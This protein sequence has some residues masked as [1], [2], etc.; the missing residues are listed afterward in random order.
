[1]RAKGDGDMKAASP[2]VSAVV[3]FQPD[4][5]T[6]LLQHRDNKPGISHPNL[7]VFPGGHGEPGETAEECARREFKEESCYDL[8]ELNLVVSFVDDHVK[9]VPP[10]QLTI[11]WSR[12][13]GRQTIRCMEGQALEFV[14]REN[15]VNVPGYLLDIWDVAIEKLRTHKD[16]CR[17]ESVE[18]NK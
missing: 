8:D 1:M 18:W 10:Y 6:A 3:L 12:Y 7:W 17:L 9:S 11:F 2:G 16:Q 13:D 15:A 14:A 4:G 5:R